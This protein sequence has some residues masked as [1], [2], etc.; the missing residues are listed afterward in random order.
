M[1]WHCHF[2]SGSPTSMMWMVADYWWVKPGF[3][4]TPTNPRLTV[5]NHTSEVLTS[6]SFLLIQTEINF[7][8]RTC[9][10]NFIPIYCSALELHLDK[11]IFFIMNNH[12][13]WKSSMHVGVVWKPGLKSF[14]NLN[15]ILI[16]STCWVLSFGR[17]ACGYNAQQIRLDL[18]LDGRPKPENVHQNLF[19]GIFCYKLPTEILTHSSI[20]IKESYMYV[21]NIHITE[22]LRIF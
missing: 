13:F 1:T 19:D 3:H 22:S 20:C 11:L 15:I 16:T 14:M 10:P 18:L 6:H 21:G 8:P 5:V 4:L 2:K 17:G 9:L 7:V 12:H